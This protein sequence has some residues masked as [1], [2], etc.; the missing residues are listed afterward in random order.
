MENKRGKGIKE[1]E[2]ASFDFFIYFL[3][4]LLCTFADGF[5]ICMHVFLHCT[6]CVKSRA[7]VFSSMSQLKVRKWATPTSTTCEYEVWYLFS[8][9]FYVYLIPSIDVDCV[10]MEYFDVCRVVCLSCRLWWLLTYKDD[11]RGY[12]QAL[13]K[14]LIIWLIT[15]FLN[16]V[17]LLQFIKWYSIV[18]FLFLIFYMMIREKNT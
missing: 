1:E 3:S 17:Y 16:W 5:S 13:G 7:F 8:L 9:S 15:S 4:G 18:W 10:C 6:L 11:L 14:T 12:N 2:T